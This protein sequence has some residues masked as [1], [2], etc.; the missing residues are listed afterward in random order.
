[1]RYKILLLGIALISIS[2]SAQNY[3]K[4]IK[5]LDE[6][7]LE[8]IEK[9]QPPGLVAA[10]V[11][12][13]NIIFEK[14][15]GL[16][17]IGKPA[18][19][20]AN[21][22]FMCGSTTKAFI[23][24][25]LAML[26][27]DGKL[28]WDDKV[29]DH[30]PEFQLKDPYITRELNIR[31]LLTHRSGLGNTDYLW[32][33]MTIPA[34]SALYKLREVEPSYSLRSSFIYQ[35]LM[36]L[37]AG[38]VIESVSGVTWD[39]FLKQR[40]FDPLEMNNA[41]PTLASVQSIENKAEAH[42]NID[43]QIIRT[44]QMSA[45]NIGPAGS[46]FASISDMGKWIQFLLN[47]GI[48]NG[49][50]LIQPRNFKELFKP[51]QI[52]PESQFYPTRQLTKP[53]WMTYGLGWFQQDYKGQMVQFHTGSLGGMVAIAGMIPEK[54]LGVYVMSNLD[55]VE[56]RHAIM[57]M[58][59]DLFLDGKLSRDWSTD[60]YKLYHPDTPEQ[61]E[62]KPIENAE[63][64]ISSS[65]LIGT[66]SNQKLGRV[67]VSKDSNGLRFNINDTVYGLLHHWHFNTYRGEFD[68]KEWGRLMFTFRAG[69]NGKLSHL[70]LW[71]ESFELVNPKN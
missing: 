32:A 6:Y 62:P 44:E 53:N 26:V 43:D 54:E 55:H 12:D 46:M 37:A 19:V 31:D 57:Y 14:A 7:I 41:R 8:G 58:V 38:K 24:A 10:V 47:D 29:I 16:R 40:I 69:A 30:L 65:D 48:K 1:M 15:Y 3:S 56:L 23:S 34:D 61:E 20:D 21:T 64:S 25:G 35:N 67:K 42:H 60:L 22:L 17:E 45:D 11:K 66:F 49:D 5:L 18:K 36:Y 68:K 63:P 70:D 50:T 52:I 9:W 13:G 4:Q 27:D 71:G 59:F 2:L 39:I 33:L 51:H 28:T